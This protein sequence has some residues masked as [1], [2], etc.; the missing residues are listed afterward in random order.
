MP[1]EEYWRRVPLD[2][3]DGGW[4][5]FGVVYDVETGILGEIEHNG[6]A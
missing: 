6:Y 3:C 5:Y 1:E 2:V 4:G